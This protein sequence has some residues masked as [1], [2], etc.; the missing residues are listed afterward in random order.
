M[1]ANLFGA[2]TA[3][4]KFN[5]KKHGREMGIFGGSGKSEANKRAKLDLFGDGEADNHSMDAFEPNNDSIE[6]NE[7]SGENLGREDEVNAFRKRMH[8][9]VKGNSIPTPLTSF[10]EMNI[11]LKLKETILKNIEISDWKE[12][13]PIQMQAIPAML[14][15]RDVLAAAPTG[16]GKTA[17]FVIPILS[18]LQNAKRV[19]IRAVLL[20]PTKE[21]A[22]QIHRETERLCSGKKMKICLLKKSVASAALAQQNKS[23]FQGF[24]LI[25]STP[26][27]LLTMIR[28]SVIDLQNVQMVVLD[29]VDKLF[30]L[31]SGAVFSGSKETGQGEEET[32]ET[33]TSKTR[34]SFLTQIDEILDSC[35]REG[36]QCGLFSATIGPQVHELASSILSDPIQITIGTANAGA[37]TIE[38]RLMF[39]GR[40]EG[41]LLAIRQLV[42]EG[43]KPPVLIFLQNKDRA[44]ELFKELVYDGINVDVIHSERTQQQ[45]EEVIKR[46]RIGEIWV[47][48]CTDL[49]ARGVDFKGVK[50]VINYDLPQSAVAYI[51]RIGRTGR[52]NHLGEAVTFFTEA[53]IPNMRSIVNVMKLSGSNVP[54][55]LL[56]VK[57]LSTKEKRSL[58]RSAPERRSI[59]TAPKYDREKNARKKNMI[60]QSKQSKAK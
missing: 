39:V 58:R 22:E 26:M 20:A 37:T 57:Q 12:P 50:M 25:I 24:D 51:H 18:K 11:H 45:R 30:E 46:F 29:E 3:G 5:K 1:I 42:Q 9:N 40:E 10:R 56:N 16:S 28:A 33:N 21:L 35:P 13:T 41:K 34:S 27:R 44:K 54:E 55:W 4:T 8:I 32:E 14:N 6:F 52:A 15:G 19:G 47:L 43:L 36:L 23:A 59:S 49:L 60:K 17:A 31:D 53:D 7:N 48:I 38:Q 2:L